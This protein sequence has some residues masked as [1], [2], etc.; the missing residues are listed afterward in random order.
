MKDK[1]VKYITKFFEALE[2]DIISLDI[3]EENWDFYFVKLESSD[4]SLLIWTH[5]NTIKSLQRILSM[6][7]NNFSD[8]KIKLKL[9]INDYFKSYEDR[10]FLRVDSSII[11]LRNNW[12]EY[13]LWNL[14]PYD[15]KRIHSYIAR[16]YNDISSKSR[17]KWENRKIFLFLKKATKIKWIRKKLTIDID[18]DD[19]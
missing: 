10:L 14:N 7:I 13:N 8:D 3:R 12:L 18:G 9:E 4:S 6:C 16:K 2:I 15:R 11:S 19:I 1:I 5:W 17:W